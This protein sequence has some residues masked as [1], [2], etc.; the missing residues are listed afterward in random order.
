MTTPRPHGRPF[1]G[2]LRARPAASSRLHSCNQLSADPAVR[3]FCNSGNSSSRN[4]LP[5]SG[6]PLSL[7][8][9]SRRNCTR[10]ILPEIVFSNY[11]TTMMRQMRF[12]GARLLPLLGFGTPQPDRIVTWN[13]RAFRDRFMLQQ[14]ALEFERADPVVRGFEDVIGAA[15]KGQK[16]FVIGEHHVAAAIKIAV[17]AV[18]FAVLALIA[19]H[20]ARRPEGAQQQADLALLRHVTIAVGDLYAIAGHRTAHRSDLH[21]LA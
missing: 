11:V 18:Q 5:R 4:S 17:G 10:R 8:C 16:T 2:R 21:L 9:S 20:Q 7:S 12:D 3:T 19:L 14:N 1:S 13:R 6:S 15:D